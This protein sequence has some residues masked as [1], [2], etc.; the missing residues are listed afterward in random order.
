M[1]T[2]RKR[3]LLLGLLLTLSTVTAWLMLSN[4]GLKYLAGS[5]MRMSGGRVSGISGSLL[6][7]P[8]AQN[9]VINRPDLHITLRDAHLAWRPVALL[10]GKLEIISLTAAELEIHSSSSAPSVYP[11]TLQLPL[12]LSVQKLHIGLLQVFS[13]ETTEFSARNLTAKLSSDGLLHQLHSLQARLDYGQ[14]NASGQLN[15]RQPFAIK[16]RADLTAETALTGAARI[17]A[18]LQGNLTQL[19]LTAQGSGEKFAGNA[20]MQLVPYANLPVASLQLKLSGLD[21]HAFWAK[22]PGADL[23][24]QADLHGRQFI[25]GKLTLTNNA[26]APFDRNGLPL[27]SAQAQ[28]T[29]SGERVKLDE[30]MLS[31]GKHSAISGSLSWQLKRAE[32]T[33]DLIIQNLDPALMDTRL[34]T[35]KLAG[36]LKLIGDQQDQHGL[37]KLS[38]G[39][40][41]LDAALHKTADTLTL[42]QLHLQRGKASLRASGKL[43]LH[44]RLLFDLNGQLQRFDLSEFIQTP[45]SHLN[46]DFALKGEI[47]PHL[48]GRLSFSIKDS[49]LS[50][51]PVSGNGQIAFSGPHISQGEA[52][53]RLGDN[54]LNIHGALGKASDRLQLEIAAPALA[55][56]G[57]GFG[58]TL[59]ARASWSGSLAK[60]DVT[61]DAQAHKL[62]LPGEHYLDSFS[63]SGTLR[64]DALALNIN[65]KNYRVAGMQQLQALQLDIQGSRARNEMHADVRID[66]ETAIVL[67]AAGKLTDGLQWQGALTKLTGTG[68]LPFNL[69]SSSSLNL[70]REHLSVGH[71]ELAFAGGRL[72]LT[73]L[74]WTPA[75]WHSQGSFTGIGLRAGSG[76]RPDFKIHG[77]ILR[78]G[79]EWYLSS[80][81]QSHVHVA[82]ESGDWV[83]PGAT[84]LGLQTL[85]F[86]AHSNNGQLAATLSARGTRLGDWQAN[87]SMPFKQDIKTAPLTGQVQ[88]KIADL[89]WLGPAI[90][91]NLNSGGKLTLDAEIAG[92]LAAPRLQGALHGEAL[93]L[94]LLDQGLR[95]QQG[96]LSAHFDQHALH[97]DKLF[98]SVPHEEKPKDT[99]LNSFKLD[100]E[101]GKISASGVLELDGKN[102][103]LAFSA[104]HFPLSLRPDRWIIA[105]GSGHAT[106]SNALLA[107][108]GNITAEAGL[109]SQTGSDRPGLSDDVVITGRQTA[110]S[111]KRQ[112]SVDAVLNLGEHF[113]LRAAGLEARLAGQ[114]AI[115][116]AQRVTGSITA[117]D[118]TFEAYGQY[119][120]VQRGIVNFQGALYDPGLNILAVRSGLSVEAGV[121][122]TGTALH[123]VIKLLSTPEVPDV[124]KLSWIILGRAPS[125]TGTDSAM[126]LSAAGSI[127]G[128]GSGGITGHLKQALGVDEL[129]LRQGELSSATTESPI[130][131]QIITVGKRLSQQAF[132]SYS[133]GVTAAAGVTKLTYALTP[134]IN[135]VTQAGA[136]NAI[137]VFYTFSFH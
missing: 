44:E 87:I 83:L 45:S 79:G 42:N 118:A 10:S 36:R 93:S 35:A 34:R 39:K 14:F 17:A 84:A 112:V 70:S 80:N 86:N 13:D 108:D 43:N 97:I 113:Y 96:Q 52:L 62:S 68:A 38:D 57:A 102:A 124:E 115:H 32:G 89:S 25:A 94:A 56:L 41:Q 69:L 16:A 4:T 106:L 81:A 104:S 48:A 129:S 65:A 53:L 60:A 24:L 15:G 40:L 67:Q 37:L 130:S 88:L 111:K 19:T 64:G 123:P 77:D 7:S 90:N 135:I 110:T 109:I 59:N 33:A 30:L 100:A 116:D 20:T 47:K 2:M 5:V 119:L 99:L 31:C 8:G 128:G 120:N 105:S 66:D 122:V 92:S 1:T 49:Q 95:L 103:N 117:R 127:L 22:A 50:G 78:L 54:H 29:L 23:T 121:Q 91:D 28:L 136:D 6:M 132:I 55:Q 27:R 76:L 12:A 11:D 98:F 58:G 126:L 72:H 26:P 137:D 73:N 131:S 46:A 51:Q 71:A 18:R 3:R 107:L 74:D 101:A 21:P 114:L 9:L 133:Q 63:G 125:I 85:Q 75:Q 134:R 61:L 82:R